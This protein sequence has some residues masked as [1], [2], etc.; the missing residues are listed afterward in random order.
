MSEV[1][2]LQGDCRDVLRTLQD[3]SVHCCVTS[4]PYWGLRDYGHPEQIGQEATHEEYVET[5]VEVMREVR[6]ALRA[7]GT[8]WLNLGDTYASGAC[9]RNPEIN[10]RNSTTRGFPTGN[11][12]A[13][14]KPSTLGTGLKPKDLI[15]IPWR[16]ALALQADGWWLRSDTIWYKPNAMP[17]NVDDRPA[18]AH[19]YLFLLSKN[20]HYHYD[21]E[22]IKE[23]ASDAMIVETE[24]GYDGIGLKDYAGNGV[25]N[26][27]DVKSR[28][29]ANARK[30][31][32]QFGGAKHS[33]DTTKHSNGSIY[34]GRIMVNKRSVWT[35]PTKPYRG[36]HFAT[37]PPD[38]VKPCILAGCPAGGTALDP[39]GGSG[40]TAMVALE[41][42][43]S[44]IVI[45]LNADY[46][47]LIK[48]RTHVTH[49]LGLCV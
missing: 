10:F 38:L 4:P 13:I 39:F 35:I 34:T 11:M 40:T 33:G 3:E 1:R 6:R 25:Q 48:K 15:G 5:L 43:R 37:F 46:V 26:P 24:Q 42:G 16:V 45:E 47:P 27:S 31:A 22:A 8:L 49:G 29:I 7:D 44:A 12:A 14:K 30:R 28:I 9:E 23:P 19:E 41:L 20:E 2:I 21:H 18:R 32:D 17:E 36:S